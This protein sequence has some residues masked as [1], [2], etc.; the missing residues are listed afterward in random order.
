MT[1]DMTHR[2]VTVQ[3]PVLF[4]LLYRATVAVKYA[5]L[6]SNEYNRFMGLFP[7]KQIDE[8]IE[9]KLKENWEAYFD[10]QK[11]LK[12]YIEGKHL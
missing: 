5:S 6:H 7:E 2:G 1:R 10:L 8:I 11:S 4:I 12:K 3:I 9:S